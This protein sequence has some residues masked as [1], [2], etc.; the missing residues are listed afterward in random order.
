MAYSR[1]SGAIVGMVFGGR[2]TS[3]N[4]C[5]TK[6]LRL[7]GQVKRVVGVDPVAAVAD[8]AQ[9]NL[10]RWKSLQDEFMRRLAG[11]GRNNF[12]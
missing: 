5:Y 7:R 4:V 2:I 6:L 1:S 3:Y 8:L 10:D 9:K 12:V 11:S